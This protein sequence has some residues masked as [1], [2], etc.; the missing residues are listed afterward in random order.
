MVVG[1]YET[2]QIVARMF[3][4]VSEQIFYSMNSIRPI[5]KMYIYANYLVLISKESRDITHVPQLRHNVSDKTFT[6]KYV[7]YHE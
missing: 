1:E 6:C 7:L 2:S 3:Q 4:N 5:F